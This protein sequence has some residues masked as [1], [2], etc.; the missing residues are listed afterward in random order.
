MGIVITATTAG[1]HLLTA[2]GQPF[3]PS[4][5][6]RDALNGEGRVNLN[7][8]SGIWS[9]PQAGNAGLMLDLITNQTFDAAQNGTQTSVTFTSA[10][11]YRWENG[12]RVAIA[13][14]DFG[15]GL[16]VMAY[17]DQINGGDGWRVDVADAFA[18]MVK[19]QGITFVGGH[20]HDIFE[21]ADEPLY[22]M[23]PTT[24]SLGAGDDIGVGTTGDD[25]IHGGAGDDIITDDYGVNSLRGGKGDDTITVGD[26][27]S[28][29]ILRGGAG[30]DTLTSGKGSD[31]LNG[32][33]GNDIIYGGAGND[34]LRGGTGDD[35]LSGGSGD[36]KLTGGLGADV[37]EFKH[38]SDG[39]DIIT[40]FQIGID[41]IYLSGSSWNFDDLT[42]TQVGRKTVITIEDTDFSITLRHTS[43]DNL[44]ADDF[45]F[46]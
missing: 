41:H 28:G 9:S 23:T 36:D 15:D 38:I 10:T 34:R 3:A 19:I 12:Q 37:F 43:V 8:V 2:T 21:P 20:D 42:L 30:E 1:Y 32:G 11:L 14:I 5:Y 17:A 40:D 6:L 13:T 29:S 26:N 46:A 7:L 27:S 44:T 24:V 22:Y 35:F 25:F 33:K 18:E 45:I 4:L 39:H 16:T 31:T